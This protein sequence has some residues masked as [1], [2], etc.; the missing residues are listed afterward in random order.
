MTVLVAYSSRH[1]ATEGIAERIAATLSARDVPAEAQPVSSCRDCSAY[2]AAVVGSA[3]YMFHWTKEGARFLRRHGTEL[4]GRPVWLFSSGPLGPDEPDAQ[5]RPPRETAGPKELEE[6]MDAV[7][8]HDHH[9]FFGAWH[10]GKPKGAME[11][12]VSLMPA[13]RDALPEGDFRDW[14]EIEAW[15]AEIADELRS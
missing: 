9:V 15:A 14:D 5:G 4:A 1:G 13:A 6:L 12:M 2:D 8:A 3:L 7:H 10:K 11:R